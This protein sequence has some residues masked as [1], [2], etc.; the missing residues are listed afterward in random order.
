[1]TKEELKK[2]YQK[3]LIDAGLTEREVAERNGMSQQSLNQKINR[4]SIKFVEF[5]NVL[6]SVG[7]TVKI[8]DKSKEGIK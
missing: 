1:M 2:E 6:E 4:G 5:T 8:V 7:K 3:A